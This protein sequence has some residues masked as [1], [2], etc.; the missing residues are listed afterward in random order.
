MSDLDKN[1]PQDSTAPIDLSTSNPIETRMDAIRR[2]LFDNPVILRELRSGLREK[3]LIIIL[4]L[5]ALILLFAALVSLP[6]IVS[7]AQPES[8]PEIGKGFFEGMYGV[9]LVVL[10]LIMPSLTCG[11]IS[12]ER[13]RHSLDMVLASRLTSFE[14]VAGKLGYALYY[15]VLLLFVSLPISSVSFFFGGV[16]A[17]SALSA[18]FELALYG[19]LW[20][21][22]GLFFSAREHRS[23]YATSQ[24]YGTV[25]LSSFSLPYLF[26]LSRYQM[27]SHANWPLGPITPIRLAQIFLI[28]FAM[29]LYLKCMQRLKPRASTLRAMGRLFLLF[30][31]LG[32]VLLIFLSTTQSDVSALVMFVW[33][34]HLVLAGMFCNDYD[35]PSIKEEESFKKSWF[36]RPLFWQV[37]FCGYLLIPQLLQYTSLAIGKDM[38]LVTGCQLCCVYVLAFPLMSRALQRILRGSQFVWVY[39]ILLILACCLPTLGLLFDKPDILSGI[40]LSPILGF[41]GLGSDDAHQI[42]IFG[43]LTQISDLSALVYLGLIFLSG[44]ILLVVKPRKPS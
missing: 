8:L 5:Y 12:G 44:L 24:T 40:Y 13:E 1:Q 9:Q 7:N 39:F 16:S 43:R 33:I 23:N 18:Y 41:A 30:Y 22:F 2:I 26:L 28:Y 37:V 11:A 38:I 17:E 31:S 32:W 3:R 4:M 20:A 36:S 27:D 19:T 29:F 35:L 15:L 21:L 42:R 34:S 25:L 6:S 10:A 14:I